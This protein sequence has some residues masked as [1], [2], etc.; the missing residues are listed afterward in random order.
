MAVIQFLVRIAR[1]PEQRQSMLKNLL[2]V[3][4]VSLALTSA[5]VMVNAPAMAQ[6]E[7]SINADAPKLTTEMVRKLENEAV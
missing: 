3:L 7:P 2:H 6:A 4:L 5:A 1:Y